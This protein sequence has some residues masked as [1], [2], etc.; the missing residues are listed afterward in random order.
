MK[1]HYCDP[2]PS[3]FEG[4]PALGPVLDD[5]P[6]HGTAFACTICGSEWIRRH[7]GDGRFQWLPFARLRRAPTQE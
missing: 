7:V 5:R 2:A 3:G 4:H 1:C 6:A